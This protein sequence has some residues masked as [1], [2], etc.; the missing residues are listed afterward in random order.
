MPSDR[1]SLI[2]MGFEAARVDC[3]EISSKCHDYLKFRSRLGSAGALKATGNRG[4]QPAMD[5]ILEHGE[6]PIPDMGSVSESASS[7]PMDV[8]EDDDAE[9]AANLAGLEAKVCKV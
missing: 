9:A 7:A 6:Q 3:K 8:D 2:G 4:L 1:D 5:H